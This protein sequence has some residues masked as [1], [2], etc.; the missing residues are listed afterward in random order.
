MNRTL[1][2][3]YK[4]GSLTK[5]A[6]LMLTFEKPTSAQL[7]TDQNLVAW[8]VIPLRYVRG[9]TATNTIPITYSARLAF[10]SSQGMEGNIVYG[11][12]VAEMKEG[13]T[14]DLNLRDGITEWGAPTDITPAS[15]LIKGKNNTAFYQEISVGTIET[16][17]GSDIYNPTFL[18]KVGT[19]L[20]AEAS[21]HPTLRA[22]VNLGY[23]QSE[24]ITANIASDQIQ[25]WEL[26]GLQPT[27]TWDFKETTQGGYTITKAGM[28]AMY[29]AAAPRE[30]TQPKIS[31]AST[32]NWQEQI[33]QADV[34]AVFANIS[35]AV[36]AKGMECDQAH[37]DKDRNRTCIVSQDGASCEMLSVTLK[38]VISE[39]LAKY[40]SNVKGKT[41]TQEEM[42]LYWTVTDESGTAGEKEIITEGSA[43]WFLLK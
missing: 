41:I 6:T 5:D 2:F 27:S 32:I 18:W 34:N 31:F 35:S 25:S 10:G 1:L 42:D 8:K 24:F 9:S 20:T 28:L 12:T 14:V 7:S 13:Q 16:K 40:G 4:P 43:A 26:T 3:K 22:Y 37:N 17:G 36:A 29:T 33:S 30:Y 23:M 39:V 19:R 15:T 38:S 11:N 21:F